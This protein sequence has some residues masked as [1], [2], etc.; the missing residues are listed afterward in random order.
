MPQFLN[1]KQLY[2]RLGA[3]R[4]ALSRW[5][6]EWRMRH[7]V[8]DLIHRLLPW[9][10]ERLTLLSRWLFRTWSPRWNTFAVVGSAVFIVVPL[11]GT[12]LGYKP[13]TVILWATG[14]VVLAYTI[15]AYR[16]RLELVRQNEIA[17]QPVLITTIEEIRTGT[18]KTRRFKNQIV[19]R[20]IGRG[21]A[22]FIKVNEMDL[23]EEADVHFVAKF[24][25]VDCL[26]S[27]KDTLAKVALWSHA[28]KEVQE[29]FD[30][31]S[32]L[33]PRYATRTFQVVISY[34]DIAGQKRESVMQM[35]K[36]G[37]RLLR[38]RRVY[39]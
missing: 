7:Q 4:A 36:D 33:D 39:L 31:V 21:P 5:L 35:G 14:L 27:G 11:L 24:D 8:V 17:I 29:R 38:H 2:E 30:F 20:N 6:T 12:L 3:S 32:N 15:E 23:F 25:T 26:E 1:I 16:I 19:I 37:V 10:K 28:P 18:G 9:V 34:E 13:S 22:L